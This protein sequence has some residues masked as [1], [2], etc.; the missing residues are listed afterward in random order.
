MRCSAVA[1]LDSMFSTEMPSSA[2][3]MAVWICACFQR[4]F[5]ASAWAV[6]TRTS[7]S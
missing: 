4:A 1:Q 3:L 6:L 5:I 7:S 2:L